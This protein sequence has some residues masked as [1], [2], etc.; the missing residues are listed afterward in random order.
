MTPRIAVVQHGDVREARRLRAAG[1]PEPYYGMHYSQVF[2][3]RW[4]CGLAQLVVNL[5]SARYR[6]SNDEGILFGLPEPDALRPLPGTVTQARWALQIVRKLRAFA[7]T[8]FLL[9][10][11]SLLAATL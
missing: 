7:P 4:L 6:E 11:G 10:T 2:L 5:N 9:R 3:D 8:H 1:L